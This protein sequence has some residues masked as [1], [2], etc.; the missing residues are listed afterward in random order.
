MKKGKIEKNQGITLVAL[1]ITI[2]VLLIL[3]GVALS[4]IVGE[5]GITERAVKASKTQNIAGAKEKLELDIANYAAEFYQAKYVNSDEA[6]T[7]LKGYV[8]G[9]IATGENYTVDQKNLVTGEIRISIAD[10]TNATCTVG[11]DGQECQL[12]QL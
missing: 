7:S 10:G 4:L 11:D 9:K 3:A 1:V 6:A 5:N 12:S 8:L 2:V